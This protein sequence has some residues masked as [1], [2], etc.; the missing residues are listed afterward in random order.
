[1]TRRH[2][3]RIVLAM[4]LLPLT[5]VVAGVF[6]AFGVQIPLTVTLL[7]CNVLSAV[8]LVPLG[9]V[10]WKRT[11]DAGTVEWGEAPR[12]ILGALLF[13]FSLNILSEMA[14]LEDVL[15]EQFVE[16][17]TN[18]V[19][20]LTISLIGPIVEELIFREAII[21][22]SI[23][24]GMKPFRAVLMS[25]ILFGIIHVNPAQVPF[26]FAMGMLFGL[27]Y[28]RTRSIVLTGIIHIINNSIAALQVW[29]LGDRAQ[30]MSLV[31]MLG[32]TL[33]AIAVAVVGI[34]LSWKLTL[35]SLYEETLH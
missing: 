20:V 4:L 27:V 24:N 28:L 18:P 8:L 31:D 1:M 10:E 14:D 12:I 33:P 13:A 26:A 21:G 32:G 7:I 35:S 19:G 34:A 3:I 5:Q 9:M 17:L 16:M 29:V 6:M 15:G 22:Y 23:S 25:A 2:Y 30:E 11:F